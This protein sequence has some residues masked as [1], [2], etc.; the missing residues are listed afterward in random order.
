M[1]IA[2]L[3]WAVVLVAQVVPPRRVE[4]VQLRGYN[5]RTGKL[6]ADASSLRNAEIRLVGY[7]VPFDDEQNKATEFLLVPGLGQCVHVPPPPPNQMVLVRMKQGKGVPIVWDKPV[8]VTGRMEL[9]EA[10]P[11]Y[12]KSIYRI[13]AELVDPVTEM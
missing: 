2:C 13:S 9:D 5:Y 10:K 7:M 6:N 11:P 12:G 4:W 3:L 8:L 1:R